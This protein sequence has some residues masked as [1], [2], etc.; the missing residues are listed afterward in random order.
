MSN[1]TIE[2]Q[3]DEDRRK[4]RKRAFIALGSLLAVGTL[5]TSAFFTDFALLDLNGSGGFGDQSSLYNIQVSSGQEKKVG[6]VKSWIE[7]NPDSAAIANIPGASSL[8]P[9]GSVVVT[10]P[11]QNT[12]TKWGSTL[13]VK[14]KNTTVVDGVTAAQKARNEA[15]MGLITLDIAVVDDA[16]KTPDATAWTKKALTVPITTGETSTVDLGNLAANNGG[17]V[18]YVKVNLNNGTTQDKTDAANGGTASLQAVVSGTSVA[19]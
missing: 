3:P 18:I 15:Y 6:D 19:P 8:L 13:S 17:K 2:T 16:S 7:A 4:G 5:A 14:F 12:S 10:I 1:T 9:G 11:V